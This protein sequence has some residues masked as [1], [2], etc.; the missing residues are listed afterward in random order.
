MLDCAVTFET[1]YIVLELLGTIVSVIADQLDATHTSKLTEKML[2]DP[3]NFG[4]VCVALDECVSTDGVIEQT[5]VNIVNK[6]SKMK[7][8]L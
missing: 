1:V 8:N 2:L 3:S 7:M 5:D 6:L 4:K